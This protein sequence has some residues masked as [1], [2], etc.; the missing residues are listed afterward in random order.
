MNRDC[1]L[2]EGCLRTLDEIV[3]WGRADDDFK[4]KVW[5]E[6]PH[7]ELPIDFD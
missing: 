7:R 5:A 3:Q 4:R 6:L 1:G 2:C